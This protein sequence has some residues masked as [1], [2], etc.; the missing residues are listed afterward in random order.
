MI[1]LYSHIKNGV[2]LDCRGSWL[3]YAID[4][5]KIEKIAVFRR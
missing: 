1:M 4:F 2:R 3:K 5:D